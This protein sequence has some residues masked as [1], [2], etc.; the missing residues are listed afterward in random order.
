MACQLLKAQRVIDLT[1]LKQYGFL[2]RLRCKQIFPLNTFLMFDKITFIKSDEN[3]YIFLKN[4]A[5][6]QSFSF[7]IQANEEEDA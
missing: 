1:R 4:P 7:Y 6:S 5:F 2:C 3:R